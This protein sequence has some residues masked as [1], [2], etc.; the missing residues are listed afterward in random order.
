MYQSESSEGKMRL[1]GR[2]WVGWRAWCSVDRNVVL[3]GLTSFF[4]DIS[5]EMVATVLPLYIIFNLQLSP[6]QFGFVDGLYPVSYTHL[7]VY[8][9][10]AQTM[11]RPSPPPARSA[12]SAP[13]CT[14]LS[15]SGSS[16]VPIPNKI[17][18][19][20]ILQPHA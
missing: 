14:H 4:T 16:C 10:Q 2:F 12:C 3:L 7:D 15:P 5:S 8:K 18:L 19:F 20:I 9:R 6:L 11:P 13:T 1:Q 17:S